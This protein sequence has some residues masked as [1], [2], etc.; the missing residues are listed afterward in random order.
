VFIDLVGKG[1][2][3]RTVPIPPFVKVAIDAWT[4]AAGLS[5][6]PLFRRVRRREYPEK[7]PTALSERMIW[8]IVTKYARQTGLV[9]TLAPHDMRR[10]CAKLCRDSGGDLEQ[11]Q[12]LLGHASIQTTER[13]LRSRQNLKEAVNDRLGLD[14]D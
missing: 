9:D 3:I 12:F 10:T 6:G 13:Y 1:K 2:R 5:K 11:I 4:A 8:H 7:T 14:T